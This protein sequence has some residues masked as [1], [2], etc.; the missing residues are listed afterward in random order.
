MEKFCKECGTFFKILSTGYASVQQQLKDKGQ[1]SRYCNIF[2]PR[3]KIK[4]E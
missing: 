3:D 1:F 4:E 2:I